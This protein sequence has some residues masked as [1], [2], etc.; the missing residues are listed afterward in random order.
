[1]HHFK[2]RDRQTDRQTDRH[3]QTQTETDTETETEKDR[4]T[5]RRERALEGIIMCLGVEK[6][7]LLRV[8]I[9]FLSCYPV[10]GLDCKRL[11]QG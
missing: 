6:F 1:M 10:S 3:R 9:S 4:Q 8:L 2:K 11:C 7:S 5:E